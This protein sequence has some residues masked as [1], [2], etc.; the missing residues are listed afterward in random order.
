M[1]R[2][3]VGAAAA[4]VVGVTL[5]AIGAEPASPARTAYTN[6]FD[7]NIGEEWSHRITAVTQR[8]RRRYLGPFGGEDP[9]RL[10]LVKLPP[11]GRLRIRVGLFIL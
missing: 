8:G 2:H 11:H 10:A 7:G 3:L 1:S 4:L 5:A 6:G 9:V